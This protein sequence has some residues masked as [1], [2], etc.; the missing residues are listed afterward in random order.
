MESQRLRGTFEDAFTD[1][2]K[3]VDM[4]QLVQSFFID[5]DEAEH[6]LSDI[7]IAEKIG[8]D[9]YQKDEGDWIRFFEVAL[10]QQFNLHFRVM[11]NLSELGAM[12]FKKFDKDPLAWN[13]INPKIFLDL[14]KRGF[15]T[16]ITGSPGDGKTDFSLLLAQI[17]RESNI[18]IVTNIKVNDPS[19]RIISITSISE[20]LRVVIG[21]AEAG[22][23]VLFILDE[24]GIFWAKKDAMTVKNKSLEK[25]AKLLRKLHCSLVFIVQ[26]K[27]G[28]PP[29][30][31]DFRRCSIHKYSKKAAR[32]RFDNGAKFKLYLN[33]VPSTEINFD[34][35]DLASFE[36]DINMD[37]LWN[38]VAKAKT[39]KRQR[40]MVLEYLDKAREGGDNIEEENKRHEAILRLKK[41]HP[42]MSVR[43]IA[44]IMGYSKSNIHSIL[45]R[46]GVRPST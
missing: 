39:S 45:K 13:F 15:F 20:F 19:N 17:G 41:E 25:L 6:F 8:A 33:K 16:T 1:R 18:Q 14:M 35:D 26:E 21:F 24:A 36:F 30:V 10:R 42:E 34:T 40:E 3:P 4:K 43:K 22:I 27:F 28:I 31:D 38:Y 5:M 46:K 32:I 9:L 37:R 7:I 23:D 44:H 2:M 11:D 12:N 29:L